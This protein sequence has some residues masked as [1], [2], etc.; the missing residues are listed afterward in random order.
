MPTTT[1]VLGR[2]LAMRQ[3]GS[4]L[5]LPLCTTLGMRHLTLPRLTG[6][7]PLVPDILSPGNGMAT[8]KRLPRTRCRSCDT[9]TTRHRRH[10]RL[11][12][13]TTGRYPHLRKSQKR[14]NVPCVIESCLLE[15]CP[16]SKL[17]ARP[18]STPALQ[19]TVPIRRHR[20]CPV[21]LGP[22]DPLHRGPSG[23]LACFPTW[24]P[25]RIV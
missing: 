11:L 10:R 8:L 1:H 15:I 18:M 3:A 16:T 14:T 25:R 5:V 22:K 23:A 24:P 20:R 13:S 21:S 7:I 9:A 12:P 4:W 17:C 6:P 19:R 2:G